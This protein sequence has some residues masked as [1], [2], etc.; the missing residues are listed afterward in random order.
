MSATT[1]VVQFDGAF[2]RRGFWLYV[3][4]VTVPNGATIV[5]VGR[6]GDSSSPNAQG[7]WALDVGTG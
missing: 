3:W 2:L 6:T 7:D 1:Q 5:Y 4:E